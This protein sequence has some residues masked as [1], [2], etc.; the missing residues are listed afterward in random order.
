MSSGAKATSITVGIELVP[1][2]RQSPKSRALST[3]RGSAA[4]GFKRK[5]FSCTKRFLIKQYMKGV[6]RGKRGMMD[7]HYRHNGVLY[8]NI[9]NRASDYVLSLCINDGDLG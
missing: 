7:G 8:Q 1:A 5:R 2:N 4:L 6:G 9:N 3:N